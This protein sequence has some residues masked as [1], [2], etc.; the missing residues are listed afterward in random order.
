MSFDRPTLTEL[1]DRAVA[2]IESR[3]DGADASLRRTLLGVLARM[4]AG[5]VH[6]LYGYL[7]WIALQGM[8]DTADTAQLDRWSSIWGKQRKAAATA[9]GSVTF[10][11]TDGG[12]IPTGTLL[13]RADDVEYATTEDGEIE[14]G[15]AVV[16]LA[17]TEAGA[18]GNAAS[19]TKLSLPTPLSWVKS[20]AVAAEL[21]GGSDEE[22]DADLRDRLLARIRQA[23]HGG[24]DFDY[25]QW[26]LEVG[27]V[28]R[29]WAYP[30]ELGPGTVTV[31]FMTDGLTSDGI[32]TAQAV[33]EVQA[34]IDVMRPV[35]ADV[36][37]VA[38][39]AVA[40]NPVINLSPNTAAV[41]AAVE[42]ELAD[43]LAR[44]AEPGTTV[45]ISHIREAVSIAAGESDHVLVAPTTDVEHATGAV[46]VLGT[47]TWGDLA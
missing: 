24:A 5:S 22:A 32:P 3:L 21:S 39:V 28:T 18:D 36:T 20:T 33:D 8:P 12:V 37:V 46:G 41:R 44:E 14:G 4:E 45:L 9:S 15:T 7:D 43:L 19:G 1:I 23:P 10:T 38:P 30:R 17:A 34:Y 27:G 35:T 31:R 47:I 26:A 6:G 29:A 2:D 42:A 40:M 11:G 16:L 25:V 13:K